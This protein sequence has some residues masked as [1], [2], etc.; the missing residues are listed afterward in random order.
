MHDIRVTQWLDDDDRVI[1]TATTDPA[2]VS[3]SMYSTGEIIDWALEER[4]K[5]L[6]VEGLRELVCAVA[7]EGF[8]HR[9]DPLP[10]SEPSWE[11]TGR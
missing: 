4:V 10:D 2:A 1:T 11:D 3:V 6:G 7:N 8:A 9:Y 5:S